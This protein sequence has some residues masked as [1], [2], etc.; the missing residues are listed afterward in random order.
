MSIQAL[1]DAIL[2]PPSSLICNEL[3]KSPTDSE[4]H[5]NV[6]ST[7]QMRH[8]RLASCLILPGLL[9]NSCTLH[10]LSVSYQ[11]AESMLDMWILTWLEPWECS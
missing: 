2:A 1:M 5:D 4:T 11:L 8:M 10:T 6:R 3:A 9:G 7:H